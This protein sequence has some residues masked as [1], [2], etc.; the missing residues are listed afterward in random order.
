MLVKTAP[1]AGWVAAARLL[2]IAAATILGLGQALALDPL[3]A[4]T[5]PVILTVAGDLEVT[6]SD[7]GADFDREMLY[8]L[9][10][11]DLV[12][13]T[14]W[15]D[16]PQTFRGVALQTV[17]DRVGAKGTTIKATALNDF[18]TSIPYEEAAKYNVL[19]ASE[20][21]GEEMSVRDRGPLWIVY[22]RS[23]FSELQAPEYN[24]RWAWQLRTLEIE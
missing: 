15:T 10:L 12:T 3:P 23:D 20:M 21:N 7:E 6:N 14:A 13:T 11:T 18:R 16:G 2:L 22:P 4:P 5:G 19:L 1:V 24:D 17:L 9:G 8:A